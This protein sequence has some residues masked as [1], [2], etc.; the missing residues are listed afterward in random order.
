L[1]FFIG[2][3]W[4]L[5]NDAKHSSISNNIGGCICSQRDFSSSLVDDDLSRVPLILLYEPTTM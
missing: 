4:F 1:I 2:G 5:N 3:K